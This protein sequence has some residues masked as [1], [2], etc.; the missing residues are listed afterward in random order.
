MNKP[1]L[2]SICIPTL[3][4]GKFIPETLDSIISQGQNDIE[5]I[6]S[7]LPEKKSID[8]PVRLQKFIIFIDELILT[9]PIIKN[10]CWHWTLVA[11]KNNN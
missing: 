11:K 6:N 3:N 7:K 1:P 8:L 4:R 9:I 2:L 10:F 5:I